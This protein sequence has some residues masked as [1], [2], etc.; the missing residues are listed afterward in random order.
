MHTINAFVLFVFFGFSLPT[1]SRFGSQKSLSLVYALLRASDERA[2]DVLRTTIYTSPMREG[3]TFKVLFGG[4][5]SAARKRVEEGALTYDPDLCHQ[6]LS[7]PL[8]IG[9]AGCDAEHFLFPRFSRNF[10]YSPS[11]LA[12]DISLF[13]CRWLCVRSPPRAVSLSPASPL[14]ALTRAAWT[15]RQA[16]LCACDAEKGRAI[17]LSRDGPQNVRVRDAAY[18]HT[19]RSTFF[20]CAV[21]GAVACRLSREPLQFSI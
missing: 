1:T 3:F 9:G 14:T 4:D 6:F 7:A 5:V 12:G 19:P 13:R 10:F 21:G 2:F 8:G 17:S 11:F 18:L 20:F 15:T 16:G